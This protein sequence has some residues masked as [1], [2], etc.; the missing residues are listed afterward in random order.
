MTHY[1]KFLLALSVSGLLTG[2]AGAEAYLKA[3]VTVAGDVVTLGDL[4]EGLEHST[5]IEVAPAPEAGESKTLPVEIVYTIAARSGVDWMPR[6][7]RTV[8]IE[9]ASEI[10]PRDVI[11]DAIVAAAAE[12]GAGDRIDVD[13]ANR[14]F[15]IHV[16]RG[17]NKSVA[18]DDFRFDAMHGNFT[19]VVRAPANVRSAPRT[20]VKGR[21][22]GIVEVPVLAYGIAVG[23]MIEAKDIEWVDFRHDQV[24]H[25][26]VMAMDDIV[27]Y[28]PRRAIRPG[29]PIQS[30]D[31]E[32]PIAVRQGETVTM[33][34]VRGNL[35]LAA[36][37]R[38]LENGGIGDTVRIQNIHTKRTV[39][40]LVTR[41]GEVAVTPIAE[42]LSA[43]N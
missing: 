31:I 24:R 4:F 22:V 28:A 9:R 40:A 38:A 7:Q 20:T 12:Q 19:A 30:R 23:Q 8:L 34:Y 6:G 37:G 3:S 16:P 43:L 17:A 2:T 42:Q 39:D 35:I 26:V 13:F 11:A 25:G 5:E 18:I 1:R 41:P 33:S 14:D 32:R 10:V 15:V 36:I 21:V 29:Q 27:G